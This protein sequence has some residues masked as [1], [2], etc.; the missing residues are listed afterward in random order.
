[1]A[2]DA[3]DRG[4][5][6]QQDPLFSGGLLT[7]GEL[8]LLAF[9]Y[10]V[11]GHARQDSTLAINAMT[12]P[13]GIA[14]VLIDLFVLLGPLRVIDRMHAMWTLHAAL[15]VEVV[16]EVILDVEAVLAVTACACADRASVALQLF[17][18]DVVVGE[19]VLD[20]PDGMSTAMT[21]FALDAAMAGAEAI[22]RVNRFAS[23]IRPPVFSKW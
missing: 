3:A 10:A 2:L 15:A 13:T 8:F 12:G 1:M 16:L 4:T 18:R 5:T 7:A 9:E 20:R 6:C 22:Q 19:A 17:R 11:I 23:T 21:A 14:A